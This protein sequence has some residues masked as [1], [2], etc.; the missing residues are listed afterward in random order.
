MLNS[1]VKSLLNDVILLYSKEAITQT[2]IDQGVEKL[3]QAKE[4]LQQESVGTETKEMYYYNLRNTLNNE[5]KINSVSNNIDDNNIT[6]S[7][8]KYTSGNVIGY[9]GWTDRGLQ[10]SSNNIYKI[11]QKEV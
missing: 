9:S 10:L 5:A 7:N 4:L 8:L 11:N 6:V 2:I 1:N 3:N